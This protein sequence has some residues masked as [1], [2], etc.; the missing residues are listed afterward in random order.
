MGGVALLLAGAA[1]YYRTNLQPTIALSSTESEFTNMAD[2]GKA[3]LY[4]R[5][6]LDELQVQQH[7]PT[8]ILADNHGAI[9]MA[10]AQQ[11]T[12]RTRHVE[13]KYFA[14]LQWVEDEFI[15]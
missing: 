12:K 1:V 7:A 13:M 15:K 6:I 9:K 8:M 14:C 11:P 10:N 4:I 2:A 3:A 5:W